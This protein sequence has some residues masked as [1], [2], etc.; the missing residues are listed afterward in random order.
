MEHELAP[1][2]SLLADIERRI[3]TGDQIPDFGTLTAWASS[4]AERAGG[5]SAHKTGR[6]SEAA[7]INIQMEGARVPGLSKH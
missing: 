6:R 4:E 3:S 5:T 1:L 7:Q 2:T